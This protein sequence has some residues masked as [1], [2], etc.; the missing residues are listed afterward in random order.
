MCS[1]LRREGRF[2]TPEDAANPYEEGAERYIALVG[3][4][5]P[6]PSGWRWHLGSIR[7]RLPGA[8]KGQFPRASLDAYS[9]HCT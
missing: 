5:V 9:L 1:P 8:S 6:H 2:F 7:A 4:I 3:R